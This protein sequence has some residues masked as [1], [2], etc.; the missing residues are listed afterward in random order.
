MKTTIDLPDAT[1]RQAKAIAAARGMTLKEFFTEALKE[2][3]RR[4]TVETRN[5]GVEPP[6][7]AGFG[8]LSDLADENRHVLQS[9]EEEFERISPEDLYKDPR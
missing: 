1:F 8:R 5:E 2:R 6:W 7:M 4:C 9:I 3:L